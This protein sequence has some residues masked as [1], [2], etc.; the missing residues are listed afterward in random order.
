MRALCVLAH[1]WAGLFTAVFLC[2]SGLT[3]AVISWDHELDCWLNPKLLL[4][5][6]GGSP[7]SPLRLAE[8]LEAA[9]P[10]IRISFLQLA[11]EP[12]ES[13]L[14][15]V[16]PKINPVNGELYA[17]GYNQI[18]VDPA[19]GAE[20]GRREWG[21]AWPV[22]R[23]NLMPF[24]YVLHYSLHFPE[25]FGIDR[26]G[27]WLMGGI[28]AIWVLDCFFA[29]YLTFPAQRQTGNPDTSWLRRWRPA[30]KIRRRASQTKLYFDLHRAF[31]LWAWGLLL[32]IAFTAFSL[33]LYKEVFQPVI[34][35]LSNVTPTPFDQRQK[36]DE[37]HPVEPLLSYAQVVV[38]A[39]NNAQ[40]L[41]W[42]E[43]AGGAS[44]SADYG[45][46]RVEFFRPGNRYGIAG[47][48]PAELYYDGRDGRFLGSNQP[49][50]GTAADV[51]LQVQ[52]P[53]HSG[54]IL[55]LPGRI[56]ISLVGL[57]VAMLSVTGVVIWWKKRVAR[58]H[59]CRIE[60]R[61]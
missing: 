24:L 17:P 10:E 33:N 5:P 11:A 1:R 32:L 16:E 42:H 38:A 7:I 4:S 52:F 40:R 36:A 20:L 15:G 8:R 34:S 27:I 58:G 28:A 50:Q 29:L 46:Y 30:W 61:G 51:F 3:G 13:L 37:R 60:H 53:L 41:G 43:P 21:A 14:F 26:W 23:K 39:Q 31:G 45:I 2:I 12:G 48:G 47:A 56:L 6:G 18:F 35:S 57:V 55:G 49:W 22:T 44:Y 9:H 19:T 54:R 25:I 59:S